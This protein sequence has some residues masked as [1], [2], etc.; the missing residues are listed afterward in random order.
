MSANPETILKGL[1]DKQREAVT[2]TDGAV[3]VISG[4]GS[5]KTRA[6]THRIAYLIASGVRPER[7][8]AVT[9]T[10]KAAGEIK[11]RVRALL[12]SGGFRQSALPAMG[13]FHSVGL[14]ILRAH[15]EEAGL[16]RNFGI[17]DSADQQTLMRRVIAELGLDPQR[18]TPGGMLA[19]IAKLKTELTLPGD[20]VPGTER[21]RTLARVYAEYSGR[22]RSMNAVDFGDLIALTVHLFRKHPTVLEQYRSLWS[23]ILVDEYQDT[24]HDQYTLVNLLAKGHGNLFCIGDDAQSIYQFRQADIRN[25]LNF[26]R[27]WPGATVV[28]L[29]QNYRSTKTILAAAQAVIANNSAQFAKD[30][31]TENAQGEPVTVIRTINERTEAQTV[32]QRILD[33]KGERRALSDIAILYRTHAQSRAMEEALVRAGVPYRIVG[34]LRFYERKEVKDILA[35]LRFINNPSDLVSFERIANVPRRGIG[36]ATV[37]TVVGRG[38][39]LIAATE[40]AFA[41]AGPRSKGKLRMLA[42]LL[43]GLRDKREQS[44]VR[45]LISHVV[46]RTDYKAYVAKMT[47]TLESP[48]ER[49]ENIRELLT[50]A[51]KYDDAG[52]DGL[53]R[54]LEEVALVQDTDSLDGAER[55][56]TLMTMHAAKGLEFPVVFIIGMEEGL[57]P[58]SRTT[59][60]PQELEEERRLCYVA[61]TRAKER[62]YMSHARWRNIYGSRHAGLPSRFLDEMPASLLAHTDMTENWEDD[63]TTV[64]YDL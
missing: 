19:R 39:D 51:A 54:F 13:T 33:A 60:A 59:Y 2:T 28:M 63:E 9:F 38:G 32:V 29:E 52:P 26:Q 46:A 18:N 11:E 17:L 36:P 42:D 40:A 21:E 35:Y 20:F 61:L 7:I 37:D 22:M 62:L 6:L 47:D 10:N 25:I 12:K 50:V 16:S 1:N 3:L 53:S 49:L 57:F 44:T 56:V 23:H 64:T 8:L 55:T 4:P 48:E 34:G 41:E 5:G 24:S 45:K 30:L 31:W 58:H 14:R 15:A 27:D 43:R